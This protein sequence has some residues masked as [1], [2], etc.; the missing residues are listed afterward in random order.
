MSEPNKSEAKKS[1]R[2]T[3]MIDFLARAGWG[4]A[5]IAPLPGDASTRVIIHGW[6]WENARP[7]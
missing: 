4:A 7:C 2:K 5:S 3:E 6:R 1:D